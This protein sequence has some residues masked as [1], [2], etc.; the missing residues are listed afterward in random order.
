MGNI[1]W[2]VLGLPTG[3][4]TPGPLAGAPAGHTGE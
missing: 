1:A 3:G 2:I 4:K